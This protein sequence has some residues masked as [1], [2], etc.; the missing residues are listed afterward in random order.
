M[1]H[2]E[3]L[4][5]QV[6]AICAYQWDYFLQFQSKRLVTNMEFI[7]GD[8]YGRTLTLNGQDGYFSITPVSSKR[9]TIQISAQLQSQL[10]LVVAKISAMFDLNADT[11]TI[12]KHLKRHFNRLPVSPGIHIPGVFCLFEAGIR[13][14]CGQRISVTAATRL[15]NQLVTTLGRQDNQG[16]C[17]FPHPAHFTAPPLVA[18]PM[19]GSKRN[20]LL[21]FA[22]Y[23]QQHAQ[24]PLEQI[25]NIKGIGKWTLDY[26]QLRA[27]NHPDIW[28]GTDL[29]IRQALQKIDLAQIDYQLASPYKSYLTLQLWHS[30]AS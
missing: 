7:Q 10:K 17:Y 24:Q 1:H 5:V 19:M 28:M 30:L 27:C 25:L 11:D 4:T 26:M 13:A 18:I 3:S 12:E 16:R 6:S 9:F 29:G 21:A 22:E 15:L 14:I 23:W 8:T 20:T 2:P